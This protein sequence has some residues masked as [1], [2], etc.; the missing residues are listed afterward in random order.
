MLDPVLFLNSL[1]MYYKYAQNSA[2]VGDIKNI[3]IVVK[4]YEVKLK[5]AGLK[6]EIHRLYLFLMNMLNLN[7][8]IF[9]HWHS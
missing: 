9:N 6:I 4:A 8:N 7:L 5:K 3:K 2:L 1:N